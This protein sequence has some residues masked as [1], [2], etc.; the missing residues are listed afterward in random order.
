MYGKCFEKKTE[1]K[2]KYCVL[3]I[4]SPSTGVITCSLLSIEAKKKMRDMDVRQAKT[5]FQSEFKRDSFE[6]KTIIVCL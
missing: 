4:S 6:I 5:I 3:I 1:K 2:C